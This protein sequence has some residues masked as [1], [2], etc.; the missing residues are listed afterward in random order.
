MRELG[1]WGARGCVPRQSPIE[2][3]CPDTSLVTEQPQEGETQPAVSLLWTGNIWMKRLFQGHAGVCY[4]LRVCRTQGVRPPE[5]GFH[6]GV[7]RI[8][9]LNYYISFIYCAHVFVCVCVCALVQG[10]VPSENMGASSLLMSSN[11]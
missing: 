7:G 8:Y 10:G 11:K 4:Q 2:G 6:A 1:R 5:G 9:L 3:L